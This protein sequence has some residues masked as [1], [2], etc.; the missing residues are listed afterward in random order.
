MTANHIGHPGLL[1]T[2]PRP[3]PA[4]LL[5]A[6]EHNTSSTSDLPK[7]PDQINTIVFLGGLADG[8]QTV[9][10]VSP[11]AAALPSSWR[12]VETILG[13]SY[14]QFGF[15]GLDEDVSEIEQLVTFIRRLRPRGR[16]VLLG[17]S[18]GSQQ[19]MHYLLSPQK[20]E[21]EGRAKVDGGIM[22]ACISD[23]EALTIM[24]DEEIVTKATALAQEYASVGKQ[25][26]YLPV[27]LIEPIFGSIP[28]TAKRWLS[29]AS[30]GPEHEG[31]DDY[32]SSDLP[33]ER[34]KL[35]FGQLGA[36]KARLC[37]LFSGADEYVPSTVNKETLVK[38]WHH[39]A[40][41]GN[42]IVDEASG[43]VKGATHTLGRDDESLKELI[44]RIINFLQRTERSSGPMR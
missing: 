14:R 31:E 23:R 32:F 37:W 36:S 11:L 4:K 39:Y 2:I 17:H 34:L 1:Y 21:L 10:Y 24:V 8:L 25:G 38:S 16:V 40:R 3:A 44:E 26:F 28:M 43:I 5:T 35:T 9:P 29:L 15:S 30:P 6:F 27:D 13:S 12:L 19:V 22:Q 7:T 33:E 18:T 41:Q 20:Y 42:G